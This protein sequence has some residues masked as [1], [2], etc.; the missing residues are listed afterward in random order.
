MKNVTVESLKRKHKE[1]AKA[2]YQE[3]ARL[4]GFGDVDPNHEGGLDVTGIFDEENE[5][6]S[7]ANKQRIAELLDDPEAGEKVADKEPEQPSQDV[8]VRAAAGSRKNSGG[9]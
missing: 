8:P 6:V 1:N 9:K 5:A 2:V 4:G 3:I 7:A